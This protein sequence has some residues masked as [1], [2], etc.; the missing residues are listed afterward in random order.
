LCRSTC[1]SSGLFSLHILHSSS[2]GDHQPKSCSQTEIWEC[3]C[4][5]R[6]VKILWRPPIR[7]VSQI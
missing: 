2:A 1:W 7:G 5:L 6:L 4:E 3:S